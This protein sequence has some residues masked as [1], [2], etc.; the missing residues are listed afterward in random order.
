MSPSLNSMSRPA[1]LFRRLEARPYA[2]TEYP[3]ASN[4]RT[5][6][7]P[8][9][10]VAPVTITSPN[11]IGHQRFEIAKPPRPIILPHQPCKNLTSHQNRLIRPHGSLRFTPYRQSPRSR[12][13]ASTISLA[14][15]VERAGLSPGKNS[16]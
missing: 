16:A 2:R 10:P 15:V 11:V 5:I 8:T 1:R 13:L 14:C 9:K 4:E 6:A 7:D 3:P 12:F